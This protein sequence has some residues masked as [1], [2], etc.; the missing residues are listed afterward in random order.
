M[1][2]LILQNPGLNWYAHLV[3]TSVTILALTVSL[4]CNA[5]RNDT[6]EDSTKL[7]DKFANAYLKGD[8]DQARQSLKELIQQIDKPKLSPVNQTDQINQADPLA[9]AY[10]RLYVL[11]KRAGNEDLAQAYL[12]KSREWLVRY[13]ELS[14]ES[15][16]AAAAVVKSFNFMEFVD[17]RDKALTGG[18]GPKYFQTELRFLPA[19]LGEAN[20]GL[21]KSAVAEIPGLPSG[22]KKLEVV[23]VPGRG[24][25][26]PFLMGKYEVTQAQYQAVMGNNPSYFTNGFDYPVEQVSWND[27]QDYCAKLTAGLSGELKGKMTFRLP[28]DAE[29]S[30]AVGLSEETGSTPK[31]KSGKIANVYPW[32]SQWPPPV[33]A[34][35]YDPKLKVDSF[36]TTSP[37]GSFKP[38]Q[39]G[40]YD[41]GGNIWEWCEDWW[42]NDHSCRLLRGGSWADDWAVGLLSS[43]RHGPVGDR[44][45][46]LGF[47]VAASA[48]SP[49]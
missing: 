15:P 34:G 43:N 21:G 4:G 36:D 32:G 31:D 45:N 7:D 38:N 17:Q 41:L 26:K 10:A 23:L 8:I 39:L 46:G 3:L 47:R 28:S 14:G 6:T 35:N 30:L 13:H 16:E 2:T 18:K 11:E 5:K 20:A 22:A 49:R 12:A 40:L 33:G 29:W 42:D 27:A 1:K 44:R 37:V 9:F 25:V 24:A 19:A 48:V